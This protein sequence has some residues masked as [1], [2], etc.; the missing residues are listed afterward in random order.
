MFSRSNKSSTQQLTPSIV[1]VNCTL[2]G[3]IV[4]QG[5]VHVD[6]RVDGDVHCSLLVIGDKG[7][8]CGEISAETVRVMG[9]V[10]GQIT[11]RTVELAKTA[12][13][14][15]DITHDRLSVEAGA[16]VEGRFN[17]PPTDGASQPQEIAAKQRPLLA[18][19]DNTSP[20]EVAAESL[21]VEAEAAPPPKVVLLG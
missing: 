14:V 16:Y 18:N 2:T 19:P 12:R 10:T 4:S 11:A 3:D 13:V 5:D 7:T 15:G 21:A 17:R 1:G 8:I 9:T 20:P 6:G